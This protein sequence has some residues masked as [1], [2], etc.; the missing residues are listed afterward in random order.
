MKKRAKHRQ[1]AVHVFSWTIITLQRWWAWPGQQAHYL[2]NSNSH[3]NINDI[4]RNVTQNNFT[5]SQIVCITE[6]SG[7]ASKLF[8]YLM[9]LGV[10]DPVSYF[11]P[12]HFLQEATYVLCLR[13]FKSL[14]PKATTSLK[15]LRIWVNLVTSWIRFLHWCW[16]NWFNTNT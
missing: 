7:W 4:N 1:S 5:N 12:P 2:C 14:Y 10:V 11:F 15:D 3:Y 8:K 13:G 6:P 9:K 16:L